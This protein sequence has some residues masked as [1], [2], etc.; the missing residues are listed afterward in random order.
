LPH[1]PYRIGYLPHLQGRTRLHDATITSQ[2][3]SRVALEAIALIARH[4]GTAPATRLHNYALELQLAA[5]FVGGG[6]GA[7]SSP[8][9]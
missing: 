3:R 9:G 6:W 5:V 1:S 7:V 8:A 2:Q 4:F